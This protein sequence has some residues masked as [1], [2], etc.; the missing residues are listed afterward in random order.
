V[1]RHRVAA[2]ALA[3]PL[4]LAGAGCGGGGGGAQPAAT[5]TS[6][7]SA[8]QFTNPVLDGNFADQH[9]LQAGTSGTPTPPA[10]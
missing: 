8:G 10:T 2:L 1:G 6:A 7:A 5:A 4:A 9:L 3:V